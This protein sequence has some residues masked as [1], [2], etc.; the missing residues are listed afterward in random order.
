MH[1]ITLMFDRIPPHYF[2][3]AKLAS[4]FGFSLVSSIFL[5]M[6]YITTTPRIICP[7][8]SKEL[9]FHAQK[10]EKIEG[11]RFGLP[12]IHPVILFL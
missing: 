4:Y 12:T 3:I 1:H 7:D 5:L 9:M 2:V 6:G 11:S 8:P 10:E